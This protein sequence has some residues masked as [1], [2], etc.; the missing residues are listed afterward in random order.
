MRTAEHLR[1]TNDA[2]EHAPEERVHEHPRVGGLEAERP[3]AL[4][5]DRQREHEGDRAD[6]PVGVAEP[7][8]RV[9]RHVDLVEEPQRRAAPA[10]TASTTAAV[11]NHTLSWIVP[12]KNSV[13]GCSA[14]G[15]CTLL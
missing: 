12:V 4:V 10:R 6:E 14:V 13:Y 5:R 3:Q 2:V 8:R 15:S 9:A 7:R 11:A 1:S